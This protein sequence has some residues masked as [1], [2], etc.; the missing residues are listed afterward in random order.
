VADS[1]EG[2]PPPDPDKYPADTGDILH[3]LPQLA[4]SLETVKSNFGA[5]HLLDDQVRF[6]KGWF[7][8][9]LPSAPILWLA[10]ARL[11]GDMY[12]STMDALKHVYPRLSPGGF[13][14][15]DDYG[16]VPACARAVSDYRDANG[17]KESIQRID[18]DGVFWRRGR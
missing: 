12:E 1:F 5:Y 7:K 18:N 3:T 16:S 9:T 8:E 13:L 4:I 2:L 10:V 11:D 6:L 14:I 17:I 15:V